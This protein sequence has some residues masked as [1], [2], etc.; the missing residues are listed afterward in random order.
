MPY[1]HND[2][3][4][5][6]PLVYRIRVAGTLTPD[7][8]DYVRGM[9]ITSETAA[10]EGPV[11]T[12]RGTCP[13][14]SAL[15]GVLHSLANFGLPLISA[16]CLGAPNGELSDEA[17]VGPEVTA[18]DVSATE[19]SASEEG[20]A[21]AVAAEVAE[22]HAPPTHKGARRGLGAGA[23]AVVGGLLGSAGGPEGGVAGAVIGG[24]AGHYIGRKA[25]AWQFKRFRWKP[26]FNPFARRDGGAA[27]SKRAAT[28]AA[29]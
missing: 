18:A 23:G 20:A 8:S 14:S 12:L 1:H 4:V 19:E 27:Q 16:E 5:S 26:L 3:S 22:E 25:P 6:K 11:T 28:L 29:D 13:D 24:V 17:E 21:A 15:L 7:L 2:M 9:A 10:A